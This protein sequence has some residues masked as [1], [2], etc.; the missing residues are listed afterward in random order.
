MNRAYRPGRHTATRVESV[1][2]ADELFFNL[3]GQ[4]LVV[5]DNRWK[6]EV[7][8]IHST[9]TQNWVQLNLSGPLHARL[10]VRTAALDRSSVMQPVISWIE[11]GCSEYTT[12]PSTHSQPSDGGD[13]CG[14]PMRFFPC[15][16]AE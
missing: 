1:S 12:T 11:G 7:C 16:L 5:D 14:L 4:I 2:S 3:D 6:V 8:G 15:C 10:T 13:G 9:D